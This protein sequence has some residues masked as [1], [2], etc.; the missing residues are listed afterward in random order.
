MKKGNLLKAYDQDQIRNNYFKK[1]EFSG[2]IFFHLH[3][4][5]LTKLDHFHMIEFM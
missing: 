2:I 1:K 4:N 3:I 5:Y